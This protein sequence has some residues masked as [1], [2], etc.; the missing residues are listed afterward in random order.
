MEALIFDLKPNQGFKLDKV[1][2]NP[3]KK[4]NFAEVLNSVGDDN[5]KT[6]KDRI[7]EKSKENEEK[8][9]INPNLSGDDKN[10]VNVEDI[11][12]EEMKIST[13]EE[14]SY[15]GIFNYLGNLSFTQETSE[16]Q[17]EF[18]LTEI[19]TKVDHID[20]TLNS[21]DD[22]AEEQVNTFEE[23]YFEDLDS[24]GDLNNAVIEKSF[25]RAEEP[26]ANTEKPQDIQNVKHGTEKKIEI[27]DESII[28][29]E[30]NT[31]EKTTGFV[32]TEVNGEFSRIQ[33]REKRNENSDT[34]N[35]QDYILEKNSKEEPKISNQ[36]PFHSLKNDVMI[37]INSA[38][39]SDN[40]EAIDKKEILQQIVDNVKFAVQNSKNEIRIKL[41][42]ETLGE[43][44]MNIE[45]VK[46]VITA[47]IMVDNYR[48]KEIIEGNLVQFKE[49]IKDTGLEIKTF[50][51]FVGNNSDFDKQNPNQFN[52]NKE[53]R[54]F[55][56]KAQNS[57][58][59]IN[60][61]NQIELDQDIESKNLDGSLNLL[62]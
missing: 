59:T 61:S 34:N 3:V 45:V 31:E 15:E 25:M 29:D 33:P 6:F 7:V 51:V 47:K 24:N 21:I 17:D 4:K 27:G 43:M 30:E 38:E 56:L 41:K 58:S 22:E 8:K 46:G 49:Q 44:A 9:G 18:N 36:N 40:L 10:I 12:K 35:G 52:F 5:S 19:G 60:Y 28:L 16:E 39:E 20:S 1:S 42:P 55:K 2:T 48:T 13:E 62:A 57:K 53:N 26:L 54:R 32:G 11:E 50:E 14:I 37:T 23:I